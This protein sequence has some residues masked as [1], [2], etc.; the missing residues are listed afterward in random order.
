MKSTDIVIVGGGPAG[1]ATAIA[2]R[3]QAPNLTI[4]ILEKSSYDRFTPGETVPNRFGSLLKELGLW[5]SFL[6]MKHRPAHGKRILW[7]GESEQNSIYDYYGQGWH[8]S[9]PEFDQWL[10]SICEEL[11]IQVITDAKQVTIDH[12]PD[13]WLIKYNQQGKKEISAQFLINASGSPSL[14]KSQKVK[15]KIEDRLIATYFTGAVVEMNTYTTIASAANGWWYHCNLKDQ[16]VFAFF[17]DPEFL[18]AN[19]KGIAHQFAEELPHDIALRKAF[20][21][22]PEDQ[23]SN[24]FN[25]QS[26]ISDCVG[27]D[28]LAVG[29]AALQY[30]PLSGQGIYKA[31]ETGIWAGLAIK[32]FLNGDHSAMEK[33]QSIIKTMFDSYTKSRN[34]FYAVEDNYDTAFWA[35]R[36]KHTTSE[37]LFG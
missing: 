14:L 17:T 1:L 23:P 8:L 2:I 37:V 33:Y 30:D 22:V 19:K 24:W 13:Q 7:A 32:D 29:D 34:G 27:K 20:N 6:T 31:F 3:R 16:S 28:W 26:H 15:T 9:R 4:K 25:I 10:V 5:Q 11:N 35:N 18:K 12:L 36:R 21:S